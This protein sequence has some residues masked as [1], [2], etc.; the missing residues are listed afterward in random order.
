MNH[1]CIAVSKFNI[2]LFLWAQIWRIW[3]LITTNSYNI[4]HYWVHHIIQAEGL[5][6]INPFYLLGEGDAR[7]AE[8]WA[9]SDNIKLPIPIAKQNIHNHVTIPFDKINAIMIISNDI[10]TYLQLN[11]TAMKSSVWN[12]QISL[13]PG[14]SMIE[15]DGL[16]M[17]DFPAQYQWQMANKSGKSSSNHSLRMTLAYISMT[18]KQTLITD[19]A[20]VGITDWLSLKGIH[21]SMTYGPLPSEGRQ[22]RQASLRGWRFVV[23]DFNGLTSSLHLPTASLPARLGVTYVQMIRGFARYPFTTFFIEKIIHNYPFLRYT[24]DIYFT[25]FSRGDPNKWLPNIKITSVCP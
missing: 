23:A 5:S 15:T 22:R 11:K 21:K 24:T 6:M 2:C 7:R 25:N 10:I 4:V 12:S 17:N 8:V 13:E 1:K 9:T 3:I 20:L 18:C 19:F 16:S 14:P